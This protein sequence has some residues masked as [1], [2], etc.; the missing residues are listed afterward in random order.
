MTSNSPSY[1]LST[2]GGGGVVFFFSARFSAIRPE[3]DFLSAQARLEGA[4]G[5]PLQ[6]R[7]CARGM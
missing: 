5:K 7:V 3:G 1:F 4:P 2:L 6:L